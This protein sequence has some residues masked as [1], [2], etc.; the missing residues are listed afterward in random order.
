M[1]VIHKCFML[2]SN[3]TIIIIMYIVPVAVNIG[4]V[5]LFAQLLLCMILSSLAHSVNRTVRSICAAVLY[6]SIF[7]CTFCG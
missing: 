6:I 5:D 1:T 3:R 7:S 2:I 4:Q